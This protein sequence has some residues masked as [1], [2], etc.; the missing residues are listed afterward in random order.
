MALRGLLQDL[1]DLEALTLEAENLRERPFEEKA[2][3][4]LEDAQSTTQ[5]VT[6]LYYSAGCLVCSD[7]VESGRQSDFENPN[8]RQLEEPR[9]LKRPQRDA[10]EDKFAEKLGFRPDT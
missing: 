5:Q 4:F 7:R 10:S 9:L 8:M 2:R 1:E 3:A 6:K